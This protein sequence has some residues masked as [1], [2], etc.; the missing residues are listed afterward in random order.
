MHVTLPVVK[1]MSNNQRSGS[2]GEIDTRCRQ[3][4]KKIKSNWFEN[5]KP[6]ICLKF[7]E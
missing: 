1:L 3:M 6:K 5:F 4:N 7:N 2:A